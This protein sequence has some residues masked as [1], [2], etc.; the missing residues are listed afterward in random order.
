[1]SKYS[2]EKETL[3]AIADAILAQTGGTA[4][5]SPTAMPDAIAAIA[6]GID[7]SDATA[8]VADILS[9]KTAYV[10]GE[11]IT[12]EIA[13]KS[14]DDV[15]VSGAAVTVPA[16][17]YAAA[18]T[19]SVA[20][21]AQATPSISVSSDGLITASATQDAGY[22]S[23]GTKSATK[24]LTVQGAQTITP[25]TTDQTIEA[26]R[27]LTGAQT[28]K[29][30]S[31]LVAENIKSGVSIFG[32]T[33][34]HE[35]DTAMQTT[36]TTVIDGVTWYI[37]IMRRTNDD[38][39]YQYFISRLSTNGSY[40][41]TITASN[42]QSTTVYTG[43]AIDYSG[44]ALTMQKAVYAYKTYEYEEWDEGAYEY[45]TSTAYANMQGDLAIGA[46]GS[47]SLT[48]K[49]DVESSLYDGTG[50]TSVTLSDSVD[51][52]VCNV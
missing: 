19:K 20:T 40:T 14:A 4:A 48:V 51:Y 26:G 15:T 30:D 1:M 52:D 45:V 8:T 50:L 13:E 34:T 24:Q 31:N 36:Y 35:G 17:Y 7:T 16:G 42:S 39:T 10:N 44:D 12:G 28:I 27:Y 38:G 11:K 22:V 29:G 41:K 21:A 2:I 47:V 33:G 49:I 46:D 25:T 5:L 43:T 37:E 6:G 32:V 18:V 3:D 23:A 9:G